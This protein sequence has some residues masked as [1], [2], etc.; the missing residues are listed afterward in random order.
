MADTFSA[1]TTGPPATAAALVTRAELPPWALE[2]LRAMKRTLAQGR[3]KYTM[4]LGGVWRSVDGQLSV[5]SQT[6]THNP[7]ASCSVAFAYPIGLGFL[8]WAVVGL[9]YSEIVWWAWSLGALLLA[10]STAGFVH[11]KSFDLRPGPNVVVLAPEGLVRIAG[12]RYEALGR[13]TIQDVGVREGALVVASRTGATVVLQR[14]DSEQSRAWL[15]EHEAWLR[16]WAHQGALPEPEGKQLVLPRSD[17]LFYAMFL[18]GAAAA[19]G[20]LTYLTIVMPARSEAGEA[21]SAFLEDAGQGRMAP[22]AQRLTERKRALLDPAALEKAL[23]PTFRSSSGFTINGLASATTFGGE[24]ALCIDGWLDG[25]GRKAP[26]AFALRVEDDTPKID[27]WREGRC[28]RE[29]WW[30]KKPD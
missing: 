1:S 23:P 28:E 24:V 4:R 21:V 2:A 29:H 5:W 27:G 6:G 22:A 18:A 12:G 3:G 20:G 14:A 16:A 13:D 15:A 8:V 9:R 19:T 17:S 11:A 25:A 30:H 26:Y 7:S 10:L